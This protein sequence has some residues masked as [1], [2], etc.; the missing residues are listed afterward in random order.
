[1]GMDLTDRIQPFWDSLPLE[2]EEVDRLHMVPSL[3]LMEVQVAAVRGIL[4]LYL[5]V[6]RGPKGMR[7]A[8]VIQHNL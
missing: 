8:R 6:E 4:R 1:M 2:V 7:A 5:L 3:V